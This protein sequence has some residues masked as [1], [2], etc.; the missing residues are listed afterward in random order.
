[1][2][3]FEC[4]GRLFCRKIFLSRL[5]IDF[6]AAG[7]PST[8][9]IC[10]RSRLSETQ[11]AYYLPV[12]ALRCACTVLLRLCISD[13]LMCQM[14]IFNDLTVCNNRESLSDASSCRMRTI[15]VLHRR[16]RCRQSS[17]WTSVMIR[18]ASKR[19]NFNNTVQAKR[20]A[21]PDSRNANGV[22]GRRDIPQTSLRRSRDSP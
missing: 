2:K 4:T 12:T 16:A 6:E 8:I 9:G 14:R 15:I 21:V 19:L 7:R 1:M 5:F 3:L 11:M 17:F 18:K 10:S 22:S 20:S 13:A